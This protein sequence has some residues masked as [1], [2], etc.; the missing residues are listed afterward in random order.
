MPAPV[1]EEW[2]EDNYAVELRIIL[3]T[4]DK[5]VAQK[6]QEMIDYSVGVVANA[7]PEAFTIV[8]S[9]LYTY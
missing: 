4:N 5:E 1:A 7:L 2:H 3:N 8:Q 9:E 6:R